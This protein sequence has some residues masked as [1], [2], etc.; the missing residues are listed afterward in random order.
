MAKKEYNQDITFKFFNTRPMGKDA[1]RVIEAIQKEYFKQLNNSLKQAKHSFKSNLEMLNKLPDE[2]DAK[3]W[4]T[5]KE[6]GEKVARWWNDDYAQ[7]WWVDQLVDKFSL[8]LFNATFNYNGGGNNS[9]KAEK[10]ANAAE[11]QFKKAFL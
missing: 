11:E 6:N 3:I 1:N 5:A 9:H 2:V 10:A 4:V 7:R 8:M